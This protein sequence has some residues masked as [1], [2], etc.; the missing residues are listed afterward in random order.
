MA[1]AVSK[2][3]EY[4]IGMEVTGWSRCI[5]LQDI[6]LREYGPNS[7]LGMTYSRDGDVWALWVNYTGPRNLSSGTLDSYRNFIRGALAASY[8]YDPM[9]TGR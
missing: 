4:R 8:Y 1:K 7:N 6:F 3:Y 9:Q 5:Q 2:T